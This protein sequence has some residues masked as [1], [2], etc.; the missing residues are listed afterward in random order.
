[1]DRINIAFLCDILEM[2]GQEMACLNILKNIDRD[3]FNPLVYSFRGGTLHKEISALGI[4]V[5][6]GSRKDPLSFRKAWTD[7]DKDEKN[8]YNRKLIEHLPGNHIA[9]IFA[10]PGGVQ[11]ARKAGIPVIIE[12]LDG[13]RLLDKIKDKSYF[14]KIVCQ[15]RVIKKIILDNR[16]RFKCRERQIEYIPNGIDLERFNPAIYNGMRQKEKLGL[17]KDE[18]VIGYVGRVIP[19]KNL[20]LLI[21]TARE[22]VVCYGVRNFKVIL[23]GP[24]HGDADFLKKLAIKLG[25]NDCVIFTGMKL[26]V[27]CLLSAFDVFVYTPVAGEGTPNAIIEAMAMGLPIVSTAAGSIPEMISGNGFLIND[28][29]PKLFAQHI[30]TLMKDAGLRK[31]MAEQSVILSRRYNIR[32]TVKAYEKLFVRCLER[33]HVGF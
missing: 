27:A 21:M 1:V 25:V 10:W 5:L 20:Q 19:E 3:R 6:I 18:F 11:A 15:S 14:D 13:P 33:K 9:L 22:L 29:Q 24:D 31:K 23:V 7:K 17:K 4:K 8:T 2:G 16:G 12:K 32:V 30:V 26:D 28:A